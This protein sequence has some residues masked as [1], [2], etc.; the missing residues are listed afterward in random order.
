[1]KYIVQIGVAELGLEGGVVEGGGV[2]LAAGVVA[3]I[4][5]SGRINEVGP[6]GVTTVHPGAAVVHHHV[7]DDQDPPLL[8]FPDQA[9]Q[10]R[11]RAHTGIHGVKV[12]G[13]VA[14]IIS[15]GI[16]QNR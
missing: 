16:F 2:L 5:A 7:A 4:V 11:Q 15:V 8:R 13:R 10:I 1:M 14:V 12:G 9:L 3:Q 6:T